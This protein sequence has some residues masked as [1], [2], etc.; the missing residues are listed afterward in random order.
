MIT[1][2]KFALGWLL[3]LGVDI[4]AYGIGYLLGVQIF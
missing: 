3:A 2:K 4:L 1:K